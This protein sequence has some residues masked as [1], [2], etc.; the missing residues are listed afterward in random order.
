MRPF[1]WKTHRRRPRCLRMRL[2]KLGTYRS[3]GLSSLDNA[4]NFKSSSSWADIGHGRTV[5]TCQFVTYILG[6]CREHCL[7]LDMSPCIRKE[8]GAFSPCVV[9]DF[10]DVYS[11]SYRFALLTTQGHNM[12]TRSI[13][14]LCY[15]RIQTAQPQFLFRSFQPQ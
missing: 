10:V 2:R 7:I 13:H 3:I 4:S 14:L 1:E 15:Q 11:L 5:V 12:V 9:V 6:T 8:V